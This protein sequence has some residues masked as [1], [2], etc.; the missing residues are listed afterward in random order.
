MLLCAYSELVP[1]LFECRFVLLCA[2]SELVPGLFECRFVL[3]CAY[4]ELVPGLFTYLSAVQSCVR[5][6]S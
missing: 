6:M 2:Y 1:G 4:S 3:L 5:S